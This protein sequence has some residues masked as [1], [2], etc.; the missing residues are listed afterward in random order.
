MR[1]LLKFFDKYI[2]VIAFIVLWELISR[3]GLVNTLFIPPFTAILETIWFMLTSGVLIEHTAI[4]LTRAL[5]GFVAAAVIGIPLGLVLGGWFKRLELALE[6]VLEVFS[7][8]NPFLLFHIIILFLGIG[9]TPKITIIAWTCLWPVLFNTI[10][11]IQNVNPTLLKAGRG[12]GLGP[13]K[14]LYKIVFP[15]VAPAIFTGL[16]LSAGYSL[17]MLI[18]AEMMGSSSGLG[19]LIYS[20]Q[21]NFQVPNIFAPVVV[22][23]VLGLLIDAVMQKLE[24]RFVVLSDQ[25]ALNS[26]L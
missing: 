25:G 22:I 10:S 6:P 19:F 2:A 8:T 24:K 7:Q 23:A 11:G 26:V 15:A 4:S 21:Q 16:R 5:A 12:F 18:A 9:E 20:S 17:F 3:L 1:H 14:I 13:F